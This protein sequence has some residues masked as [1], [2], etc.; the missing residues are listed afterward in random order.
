MK[1]KYGFILKKALSCMLITAMLTPNVTPIAAYAAETIRNR[2]RYVDFSRPEA[3]RL[4]DLGLTNGTLLETTGGT[5]T[6]SSTG[7]SNEGSGT[8]GNGQENPGGNS[9]EESKEETNAGTETSKPAGEE[10]GGQGGSGEESKPG[11]SG[12]EESKPEESK[13]EESKPG[14]SKPEESKPEESKPGESQPEES[15]PG[16]SKPGESQ[17]GESKPGESQSEESQPEESTPGT[18]IDE[19]LP[20][21]SKP[22]AGLLEKPEIATPSEAREP[23]SYYNY[24]EYIDEPDG[25]LVQFNEAYR[26]YQTGDGEYVTI[27]GGY[28]G[29]Y[30]D[31]DGVV[32][33]TSNT[34]VESAA[35]ARARS[36]VSSVEYENEAGSSRVVIPEKLSAY[37]GIHI[38]KGDYQVDLTPDGGN[39]KKSVVAGNAIRYSDVYP[40]IDYQYTLAGNTLKEDIILLEKTSR[41]EFSF[42]IKTN[43]LKAAQSGNTI[44]LYHTDKKK[45]EFVLEAPLMI[46]D[47]GETSEKLKLTLN[48]EEGAY[49]ATVTAD[50]KWLEEEDRSYPVRID[51]S[52][53]NMVPSKFV[54]VHVAD[55]QPSKFLGNMG[56]MYAGW[57]DGYGNMR[58]YVAINGDWSQVIGQAL[59]TSATFRIGVQSGNGVGKTEIELRAP[60]SEWNALSLTWN[61]IKEPLSELQG[62]LDSPGKDGTLEYDIT[63]LMQAWISSTRL[64]AGLVLQAASEPKS[65]AQAP[66]RMPAESFYNRDNPAMGPRIDISW[67]GELTGDLDS[68]DI[69][70]LTAKVSP[71]ITD[72]GSGGKTAMG[73][74]GH[75]ISQGGSTVTWKLIETENGNEAAEGETTADSSYTSPDFSKDMAF[76]GAFN[77]QAKSGNW[78]SSP[79][80]TADDLE[81]DT[82]YQIVAEAEGKA[83][84]EDPETGEMVPG[85]ETVTSDTVETD[86]FLLYEVQSLDLL[87]RIADHYQVDKSTIL[88]D[89]RLANGLTFEGD[90][91]FIRNPKVSTPYTPKQLTESE[92]MMIDMLLNGMGMS[93]VFDHEPINMNTGDFYMQQTDAS[94]EE[95]GGTSKIERS[96]NSIAAFARSYFGIGWSSPFGERLTV[97]HN[98]DILYRKADGGAINFKKQADGTYRAPD[99]YDMVIRTTDTI[100][101]ETP[102]G[103]TKRLNVASPS[104]AEPESAGNTSSVHEIATPSDAQP[105]SVKRPMSGTNTATPSNAALQDDEG[106]EDDSEEPDEDTEIPAATAWELEDKEGTVKTFDARGLLYYTTDRRGYR[107]TLIYDENDDVCQIK[108]PSGKRFDVTTDELHRITAI[109]LP[110]GGELS[111]VYD[112]N[113]NLISATDAEGGV[114]RYEYDD[115]HHM[116]AWYDEN[117]NRIVENVYDSDGRVTRQTDAEGNTA[118]LEYLDGCT[119]ST[120]NRGNVTRYYVDGQK[121]ISRIEYP[122]GSQ[123]SYTYTAD[124]RRATET[125]ERGI[126]TSYTYDE[127]GNI[128]TQTRGDGTVSRFTWNQWSQPLSVTDYEGNTTVYTYDEVGN[129]L[130]VTDGEG[131]RVTYNYDEQNRMIS[132]TD[133]N[134]G[135]SVFTYDGAVITSMKDGEGHVWEFTYDSM[136]QVLTATD[137]LGNTQTYE[138]NRKGW[139][140]SVTEKDGGTSYHEYDAVGTVL[141][142][143]DAMGVKTTFTYDKMYNI[144]SGKDALG[145]TLTYEY[146]KNYNKIKEIDAKGNQTGYTYDARNRLVKITDALGQEIRYELDGRGNI[147][148]ATDRRGK[149]VETQYHQVLN[150]P[151]LTKD[152][153]GHETYYQYDGNG[154]LKKITYPDGTA[155]TYAYDKAGRAVKMTAQ[156]GLVTEIGY[157]GNG[158][159]VRITDD[160]SRVYRFEYDKNNRLLKSTD[161]LGGETVYTYDEVGNLTGE[162]DANG[163]STGYAYDAAG[164]LTQIKDALSG[165]V[166]SEYDL[167]GNLLKS[168][169]QNNHTTTWNYDV[170]GQLLAQVN[171][172]GYIT[173][174]E[175]DSLG[176]VSKVTDALKGET[177]AQMDALSRTVQK[178]DALGGVYTY[179]YD[180]NGNLLTITMPDSDTVAMSYDGANRMTYYRDEASVVTR[181]E[182]D[183]MGRIVKAQDTAGNVMNYEYDVSGNLVKQVDTIGR[184]AVYEY[185]KFNRLIS[186]TGTDGA[187]TAYTYDPLDRLTSVTQADGTV[188]TYE[189]DP[190]GNLIKTTE[191]GE[192]VYTYAYDAINR[193]TGKVNPLGASTQ[194]Q[195]D[196]KGNLL[197]STDANGVQKT[198]VYDEIDR[199]IS[200]TDGNGGTTG[201]GY[202]ELSR[203]I[204]MVTPEGNTQ[205]YRYDALGR[206][207][208]EKDANGLITEHQYDVMGNLVKSI[209]PKGAETSYTYDK[210]DELTS[211]TD[212]MGHVTAYEVD[213][214]R[215]VT[216]MIQK[217]GGEYS[218]TYDAV[219]RLTEMT[220]PLGHKRVFTYDSADNIVKESDNLGRTSTYQYDIMHRMTKAVNA[221]GGVTTFGYDIRGNQNELINAMGYTWKYQYDLIDQLTAGV[222]PEGKA[223]QFTYD[224]VGNLTAVKKPGERTTSYQ[225]DNNYNQTAWTDPKGYVYQVSYDK[226]NRMVGT[227]D[228]LGQTQ[229]VNYDAGS[230]VTAIRDKMGLSQEFTYDAHGN[231]LTRRATDGLMTGYQYDILD[232]LIKVTDPMGYETQYGYDEMGNITSMTNPQKHVTKYTYDLENNM[233]S[234]TSP[235]GR[236]EQF[237][238]D[239]AGRLES[240]LTPKGD[241]I[242]YD[243]D[244]L[245]GLADK[246]YENAKGEET[247]HPVQMGYNAMGQR[248]SME[249]ITGESSYT[250]DGLGRLK[251]AVNG[252]G[253]K[254]EYV[255]DEADNLAGIIYPDGYEVK[256][257]YDKNDNITKLTDRDGRSTGY[258]YDALNRLTKVTRPDGGVSRYTYNARDQIV[259]AENLCS[260]GFVISDYKYTY[261]DAGLITAETAKE[262]L[263]TSA[264]DTGHK[265]GAGDKYAHVTENPWQNQNPEWQTTKRT[266]KYDNNGQLLEC[267]EDK[268]QFDKLTYTYTYDEAGNRT[269]A[270]RQDVFGYYER[271]QRTYTYN[272]DNQMVSAVVC[273]GNLTK[274]YTFTYDANGNLTA[275]C[276]KNCAEVRYQYDTENR[277][278]A[279]YDTQRLLMAAAYDGDG[280][281]TF[282]LNYN[283]DAVCGYGKNVSGEIFMP[284]HSKNEDGSLTAEGE[285]FSYICSATGRAYDLTEYV[286]DTNRQYTEVLTAYTVNSEATDSYSYAGNQRNSR[287][288]IWTEARDVIQN[289]T[290]F[291]LYDGRGSVTGVTWDKSRVTA[292][293]QY[294]PYGQVTLGTTDHVDFYGYNG[295]SYNPNTGLE[296]LRARYYNA[297]QGRFFQEDT[298]LGDITDPLTLNR[299]AYV[300]NSPLNYVDPSGHWSIPKSWLPPTE[301]NIVRKDDGIPIAND[302]NAQFDWD[303]WVNEIGGNLSTRQKKELIAAMK[304]AE[305]SSY[306]ISCGN[307]INIGDSA[308][309][310]I[311][312]FFIGAATAVIENTTAFYNLPREWITL[313]QGRD[314][315]SLSDIMENYVPNRAA[316]YAGKLVG[317]LASFAE[318]IKFAY[319]GATGAI[320]GVIAAAPSGSTSL[321]ITA[322]SVTAVTEGMLIS[323][324]ALGDIFISVKAL[325]V[326]ISQSSSGGGAS[327]GDSET[328]NVTK[329]KSRAP[330]KGTPGSVYEQIDDKGNV[331]SKT[332]YGENGKPEYR[333]DLMGKP[334]YDKSTGQ[335]LDQ[336][337]HEFKYNEKGQPIGEKVSP[338]PD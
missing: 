187:S 148:K 126:E 321:I 70:A 231:I 320:G 23:E 290:S 333:D 47:A 202:D 173:A 167:N 268:G 229:A 313:A 326:E 21:E 205:E 26:T 114:R 10:T 87:I 71:A 51:P 106:Q 122:D 247:D 310:F 255:Y 31:E 162:T 41:N 226:D 296:Y 80:V 104:N 324:N 230:R 263:F 151:V 99:G 42:R 337:R 165:T 46:D 22:E 125:D 84:E 143:T 121:R 222:D 302:S 323:A 135:T 269:L 97:R 314:F 65:E 223:T 315:T 299:Y 56:P 159:I 206:M 190:V 331:M 150:L 90:V 12:T 102:D 338:I 208:K 234:L 59:C 218:Y 115:N 329:G 103:E 52:T 124:N 48:G 239:V 4:E 276:Y 220:T 285:L 149:T 266:F 82:I 116:T 137:P 240:R 267:K 85:E 184:E 318:G 216:K 100:E 14:E 251:T 265:G 1:K 164:R 303:T 6:E 277:L 34:L 259:E 66:L 111:Y 309:N 176:N 9:Q 168:T 113:N 156:N 270:K 197:S 256:Y 53:V 25:V 95:L 50:K 250:Y 24:D 144:L 91:L 334:H 142:I 123:K 193:L 217:N 89:N 271:D 274:K 219:H 73:V 129:L 170:I 45:P 221:K 174:V 227:V 325:G 278:A 248:I 282:Q 78:Q 67:E 32:R 291:Y 224:L 157:D 74:L 286:N 244:K 210:H 27:A 188:T 241:T 194:F 182:Y 169:D 335:Y 232:R 308:L 199:M 79:L 280:N 178:T 292:V 147:V 35:P 19:S 245:N 233:T 172:A 279:V 94:V 98:G 36:A 62:V 17:S 262:C 213:L 77:S 171:P 112:D 101:I 305:D 43:G 261:N 177:T 235:M 155:L 281:R 287:N 107:T 215:M 163:H 2:P 186:V 225:Y 246:T 136:N 130:S 189:Y 196:A 132:M 16:E 68:L 264:L 11:E 252:S 138:Y 39:F 253:K 33:Q 92:K 330:E 311:N 37:K 38:E 332:K 57:R 105:K 18:G 40:G 185:D 238:Y 60:N 153:L 179:E 119:V 300:K 15:K 127:N 293:Y 289:E 175:Y 134:G 86:E 243:Y 58:T 272:A 257:E 141:S 76:N 44:I 28:S 284:A 183:S 295:E 298:Y 13:P 3:L 195:Y 306:T 55:G 304:E 327:K 93:C 258:E 109:T 88:R 108:T 72:S 180:K 20:E 161:P 5:T 146:D 61:Q 140:I 110:N 228:P 160:A 307:I 294:D 260:C 236:V 158:N 319:L 139:N 131:N 69:D 322:A 118:V 128:L 81:T 49:K 64:Q 283:P 154:R 83:L 203:L 54:L 297:N 198:F 275:E 316:F 212:A 133:A 254:V 301:S 166:T 312:S 237:T 7:S 8:E 201:Y 317:D 192:A 273:E 63:E 209:S 328:D 117:G 200:L 211:V 75:G 29:L 336:H 207:T 288:S 96:Y 242:R 145:Q 204:S 191:P 120:D 214:N 249:D 181:Y 152:A 30:K